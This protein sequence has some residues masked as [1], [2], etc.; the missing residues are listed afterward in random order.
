MWGALGTNEKKKHVRAS[1]CKSGDCRVT[2]KIRT[3][4]SLTGLTQCSYFFFS[5]GEDSGPKKYLMVV[6]PDTHMP[7]GSIL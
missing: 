3:L 4:L 7:H 5:L 1:P 6:I 2:R